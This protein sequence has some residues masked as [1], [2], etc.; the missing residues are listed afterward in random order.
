MRIAITALLLAGCYHPSI[1]DQSFV[2]GPD[3]LCPSGFS[4]NAARLCEKS[5]S[6]P[7]ASL[8]SGLLG[9]KD[10]TGLSGILECST[11]TGQMKLRVGS[12]TSEVDTDI[13]SASTVG[14]FR[15][16]QTSGPTLGVWS[17]ETFSLPAGITLKPASDSDAMP[18]L[19]T[20]GA[21]TV[22]G[23]IDWRGF[24]GFGGLA[25]QP[26]QDRSAGVAA[27]GGAG[28]MGGGGGGAGYAAVGDSATS[29]GAG[30]A[31]YGTPDL[32][33]LHAGAGGG[34]GGDDG[35]RGG[36]G[37]GS[38]ALLSKAQIT[39]ASSIDV[40]GIAGGDAGITG[41]GGGGGGSGGSILV[42]A[43][44]VVLAAGHAFTSLGGIG[45]TGTNMESDGGAGSVGRIYL[46]GTLSGTATSQPAA[47][48]AMTPATSFPAGATAAP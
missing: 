37:G 15:L 3:G 44:Q 1:P 26:G 4:C 46:A 7:S 31:S 41:G 10:L 5:G 30:G 38:V 36:N 48:S 19:V 39:L 2:C 28:P 43:P 45:G 21:M 16:A 29:G 6:T 32:A 13:V 40:S 17:F 22:N 18:V 34:G 35:G 25:A 11:R 33:I 9:D 27:G 14:F 24:G 12:G 23:A 42:S 20:I 47:A 8:Y